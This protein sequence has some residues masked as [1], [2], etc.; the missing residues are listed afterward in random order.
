MKT[1]HNPNTTYSTRHGIAYWK[2]IFSIY[3]ILHYTE[4]LIY[5]CI[6]YNMYMYPVLVHVKGFIN[7]YCDV[8]CELVYPMIMRYQQIIIHT[9]LEKR[10]LWKLL[11]LYA[12][13]HVFD[14]QRSIRNTYTANFSDSLAITEKQYTLPLI[15]SYHQEKISVK[16]EHCLMLRIFT[17]HKHHTHTHT[18]HTWEKPSRLTEGEALV[19][20]HVQGWNDYTISQVRCINS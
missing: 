15:N 1:L 6:Q 11:S 19:R 8:Q 18:S 2:L 16:Y 14:N 7:L 20:L 4:P 9:P 5:V 3:L 12:P 13:P 17:F 10:L